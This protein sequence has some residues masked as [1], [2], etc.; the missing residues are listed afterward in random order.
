MWAAVSMTSVTYLVTEF[1]KG[2]TKSH[3]DCLHEISCQVLGWIMS[4]LNLIE[5][6]L[7]IITSKDI[8]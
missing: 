4:I 8:Y 6:I 1:L 7:I 5:L 2:V 3:N